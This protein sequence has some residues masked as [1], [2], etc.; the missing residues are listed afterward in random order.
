MPS[1]K[2]SYD[3]WKIR[4]LLAYA[5]FYFFVYTARFNHWPTAPLITNELSFTYLEIGLINALLLWGFGVGDLVHGRLAEIYGLRIW[6]LLGAIGTVLLNWITSFADSFITFVIPWTFN[7]FVNAALWG[8][9]MSLISQWWPRK[10]RGRAVGFIGISAGGAMLF[11]WA[12]TGWTAIEFGWR[13][14]FRYPPLMIII[15]AIILYLLV[16]DRPES[17]GLKKFKETD[18]ATAAIEKTS[19]QF[20]SG[21][22]P[23]WFLLKNWKFLAASHVKGLENVSRYGLATW[24]PIYYF[25]KADLSLESTVAVTIALPIGYL[26]GPIISGYISDHWLSGQRSQMIALS[27]LLSATA[28]LGLAYIPP[29]SLVI[30]AS[31]LFLGGF[32]MSLSLSAVLAIDMSGRYIAGTASGILDA[33]GYLYAGAQAIIFAVVLHTVDTPWPI[34]FISMAVARFIS[35]GVMWRLRF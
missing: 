3:Q 30:G 8:P 10:E 15:A 7:G 5:G 35:A 13:A 17:A 4:V 28:L 18:P 27:A 26:L 19:L 31:L 22:Q 29:H 9:G 33:H 20:N 1:N 6:L 21:L 34:I 24:A 2:R 12:V 32:A 14:A 23:Y 11:M 16:K 25:D